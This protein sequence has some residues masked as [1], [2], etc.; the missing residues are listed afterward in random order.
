MSP[1]SFRGAA[2][3]FNAARGDRWLVR[4]HDFQV[5]FYF[6]DPAV[7][8]RI[9]ADPEF[10]ALQKTEGPYVSSIHVEASLGWIETYIQDGKVV[11]LGDDG[12]SSY[13]GWA[14]MSAVS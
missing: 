14:A 9:S 12:K 5:E 1:A 3:A 13:L 11:N 10:Q 8:A 7:L 6:R 4:D 2:K